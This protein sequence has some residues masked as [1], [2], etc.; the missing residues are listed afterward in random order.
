MVLGVNFNK[1]KLPWQRHHKSQ[2]QKRNLNSLLGW[3]EGV[4]SVAAEGDL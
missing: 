4:L 2:V 1:L 3:S